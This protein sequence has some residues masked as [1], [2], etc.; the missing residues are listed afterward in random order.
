MYRRDVCGIRLRGCA[1]SRGLRG[2]DR[3]MRRA[4][5]L[6]SLIAVLVTGLALSAS[7]GAKGPGFNL[8]TQRL[9][10]AYKLA[11]QCRRWTPSGRYSFR[12]PLTFIL[13]KPTGRTF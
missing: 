13:T 3:S 5:I 1:T 12:T 6:I 8:P 7:A 4:A 2:S 9:E 10:V 11:L